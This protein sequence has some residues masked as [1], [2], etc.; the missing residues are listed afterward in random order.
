MKKNKK[1]SDGRLQSKVY[2]GDGQY[3]Y[4]YADNNKELTRKIDEIKLL[5]G[6]GVDVTAER[7][8]FED[9]SQRWLKIKKP[10]IS[11]KRYAAYQYTLK[12]FDSLK[13]VPIC[14]IKTIDIQDIILDAADDGA[15]K[16]T[17]SQYKSVCRQVIQ[18][19][20]DNRVLDYNAANAV[21]IPKSAPKETKRALTSEEQKWI[22]APTDHRGQ[23]AAMIMMYAGLRR[24]ELIPLLW[25]DI[26]LSKRTITINKS[27]EMKNSRP[28][29][30]EGAKTT[31]GTRVISIPKV[32]A[33]YLKGQPRSSF[34]VCPDAHG[35]M[36]T[37]GGWKRMWE[38]YMH[39]LNFRFGDF[40]NVMVTDKKTGE[41]KKYV[42]PK[43]RFAP[44]KIPMVIPP[45]TAHWLRHTYITMLYLAGIDI[46][47]AKEQAGHSDIKTTMQI[48]THLDAEYKTN[49]INKL[50]D[51]LS[52]IG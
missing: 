10:E 23:R 46:L 18:L 16:Q 2:L 39:E 1:R 40:S 3:K 25:S 11:A 42:L 6:K 24:G 52:K 29:V 38:S 31:A 17:L 49:Q 45:I 41:L 48:Y 32:L 20:I 36:Y 5:A 30:K 4:V 34:L 37:E 33:D 43:S 50:D 22:T 19:A 12:H 27:V 9:W 7:D 26:D 8:T 35:N 47:T 21:K 14:K 28:E 44:S 15:A 51:Y 13:N